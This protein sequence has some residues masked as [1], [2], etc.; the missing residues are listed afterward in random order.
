[1]ND[2][3]FDDVVTVV[4]N[5][6]VADGDYV[7]VARAFDPVRGEAMA[8]LRTRDGRERTIW[9]KTDKERAS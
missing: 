9:F 4:E 7:I 5:E 1:M 8:R 6:W 2:K 3:R